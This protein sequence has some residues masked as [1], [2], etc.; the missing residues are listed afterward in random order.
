MKRRT[1]IWIV[2][3]ALFLSG[4][5]AAGAANAS[6]PVLVRTNVDP[7]AWA[8]VPSGEFYAGQ[9][10]HETLMDHDYEMMVTHVTNAQYGAYLNAALEE[11]WVALEGGRIVGYYP[12]D[13]FHAYEHEKPIE[14]GQWLHVPLEEP[15]LRMLE[16]GGRFAAREGYE[17]HP[18]VHVTWFGAKAY[19]E[20]Y[21]WRLPTEMEWERG[22]RGGDE[23]PYPWGE[24]ISPANAN[25]YN[26][27]DPFERALGKQGDTTPVGFY[28]GKN[29]AGFT[30]LDSPSPYGL[31]DMAG[32]VWQWTGDVYEDQHY[33]YLRGGSKLEYEHYLRIWM[34]NSA[35]PDFH[36]PS[37]G[38]RCARDP[39]ED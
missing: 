22:A 25:Y 16:R 18:V 33:R 21:G 19:C 24:D 5:T 28:S 2:I 3:G 15:G 1:V 13:P 37:L 27:G 20:F 8:P 11:G 36:S 39:M 17:D 4:C 6:A 29:H 35:E 30:T 31:Y 26:S 32:N 23:R 38:F 14:E 10:A 34:R 9:F 12:G 7:G